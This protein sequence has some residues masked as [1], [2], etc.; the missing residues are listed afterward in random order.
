MK[1]IKLTQGKV[2]LVDDNMFEYLCQWRWS[3]NEG[4]A[5]RKNTERGVGLIRMHRIVLNVQ[6]GFQT[7]HIDGNG[8]NNQIGNLRM[9]NH[10]Q[11]A[12]NRKRSKNNSS[13][14]KGVSWNKNDKKWKSSIKINQHNIGLG[15][16][17]NI[18]DA[19]NA[20]NEATQKYFGEFACPN[21]I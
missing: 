15:N 2:A 9:C 6:N 4:Y 14:F 21:N 10:S 18:I 5:V 1:E 11:N 19:A 20:Y 8:L 7:D 16:F 17:I 3:Y 13:G 12:M